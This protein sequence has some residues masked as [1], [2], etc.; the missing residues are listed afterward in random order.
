MVVFLILISYFSRH[1]GDRARSL[2]SHSHHP[3]YGYPYAIV[4]INIASLA[5]GWLRDGLL[6]RHL[7]RVCAEWP[8]SID[9]Y[10]GIVC[11]CMYGEAQVPLTSV[12][13]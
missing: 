11:E 6:D 13:P 1:H 9:I 7:Y 4:V 10:H 12:L 2:L 5:L 8:P 3:Q